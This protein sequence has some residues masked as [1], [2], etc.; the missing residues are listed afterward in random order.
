[1]LVAVVS[2]RLSE[3]AAQLQPVVRAVVAAV[4]REG[5]SHPDVEDCTG[6]ALRRALE[7]GARLRDGEPVRPWVVGIARHVALDLLRARKRRAIVANHGAPDPTGELAPFVERLAAS[8][9]RPFA[10]VADRCP[11]AL[12]V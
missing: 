2:S 11:D 7:G 8:A 10:R 5:P 3:E 4:L 1:M 6:E 12:G 9:P